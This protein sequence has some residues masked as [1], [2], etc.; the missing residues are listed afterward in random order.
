MPVVATV[1]F[2]SAIPQW[3]CFH[4][5]N[6][7]R[8]VHVYSSSQRQLSPVRFLSSPGSSDES[9]SSSETFESP[10]AFNIGLAS[11][12]IHLPLR[13]WASQYKTLSRFSLAVFML[14]G[15]N[16][17]LEKKWREKILIHMVPPPLPPKLTVYASGLAEAICGVLL[18]IPSTTELGAILTVALLWAVFPSNIYAALSSKSRKAMGVEHLKAVL[19]VRLVIQFLFIY[20]ASWFV[21]TKLK[22]P[23]SWFVW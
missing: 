2:E 8:K 13:F 11:A 1:T 18:L 19:Y 17:R 20:W 9:A 7:Q 10:P 15:A 23:L 14:S 5:Q 16:L 3:R 4:R 22:G 12:V 21:N 6:V